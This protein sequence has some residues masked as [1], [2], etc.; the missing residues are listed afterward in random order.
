L[1]R[2]HISVKKSVDS[3]RGWPARPEVSATK[4]GGAIRQAYAK[5]GRRVTRAPWQNPGNGPSR[6]RRRSAAS[7]PRGGGRRGRRPGGRGHRLLGH[8]PQGRGGDAEGGGQQGAGPA[9]V[10]G[11]AQRDQPY[12]GLLAVGPRRARRGDGGH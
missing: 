12:L 10:R 5:D 6:A 8:R 2:S 7:G 9:R 11:P 4:T 1:K 3:P